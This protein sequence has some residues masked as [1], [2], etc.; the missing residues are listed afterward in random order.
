MNFWGPILGEF[1]GKWPKK[2]S[3]DKIAFAALQLFAK[4]TGRFLCFV[5]ENKKSIQ[6]LRKNK[7]KRKKKG[8]K[9]F[10]V[11]KSGLVGKKG[12]SKTNDRMK[13]FVLDLSRC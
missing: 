9:K 7:K 6:D 4:I 8:K 5:V 1:P 10:I 13:Y 12:Y 11:S 2:I 3:G